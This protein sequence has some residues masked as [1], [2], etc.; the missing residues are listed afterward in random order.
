MGGEKGEEG[1]KREGVGEGGEGG[2]GRERRSGIPFLLP[3]LKY[4]TGSVNQA[5][6]ILFQFIPDNN[7][8]KKLKNNTLK[9]TVKKRQQR[10]IAVYC[11]GLIKYLG[12]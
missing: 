3:P 4:T 11:S 2:G 5:Q 9:R 12:Y 7:C 6:I 8:R 10:L 1:V